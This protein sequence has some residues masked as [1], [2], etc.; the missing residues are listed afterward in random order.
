MIPVSIVAMAILAA[1]FAYVLVR[2]ER[3]RQEWSR[4]RQ[5][6]LTR[7]QHPEIVLTPD[8]EPAVADEEIRN[9]EL[10]D[11]IEL[12]GTVVNGNGN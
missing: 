7:I 5:L 4:E 9:S 6:L 3:E 12:V 10:E 11:E 8:D 1:L 2:H